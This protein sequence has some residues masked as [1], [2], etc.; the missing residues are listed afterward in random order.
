MVRSVFF[1]LGG[2]VFDK[3]EQ[4]ISNNS[5]Y[6]SNDDDASAGPELS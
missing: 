1:T 4:K 2:L 3:N 6:L 5:S